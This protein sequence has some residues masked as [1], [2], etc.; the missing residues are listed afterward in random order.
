MF[1]FVPTRGGLTRNRL[2]LISRWKILD[3]LRR[4]LV[5][6]AIVALFLFDWT[7]A[8]GRPGVWTAV[9]VGALAFPVSLRLFAWLRGPRP[10][11]TWGIFARTSFE[12]LRADA[13]RMMLQLTFIANQASEMLH[14]VG[15][16]LVRLVM[17]GGRLRSGKPRAAGSAPHPD[18][19]VH[20]SSCTCCQAPADRHRRGIVF[21][22]APA[23]CPPPSPS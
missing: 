15:I 19:T 7:I 17:A 16:T 5:A 9:T 2:P 1:P 14:A 22:A 8:P 10:G 4:S 21:N 23:H 3:N 18:L 6:P 20:T 13:A 12:D 11:Q